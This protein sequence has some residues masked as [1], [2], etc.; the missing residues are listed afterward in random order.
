MTSSARTSNLLWVFGVVIPI[1]MIS[2]TL[3][4]RFA[5]PH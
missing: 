5:M 1:V 4:I 2:V 3:V